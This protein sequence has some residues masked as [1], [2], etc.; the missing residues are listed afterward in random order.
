[1]DKSKAVDQTNRRCNTSELSLH[2]THF[3]N[4]NAKKDV[5]WVDL[6]LPEVSLDGAGEINLLLY[7]H[8]SEEVHYLQI[9]TEYFRANMIHLVIRDDKGCISLELSADG[10]NLFQDVRPTGGGVRF[11]QFKR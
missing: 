2:N 11:A 5:W 4:V 7:D 3:A 8:R 9:P 10:R 1:M 6:P